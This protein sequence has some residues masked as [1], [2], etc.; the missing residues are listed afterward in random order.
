MWFYSQLSGELVHAC[1]VVGHGYSGTGEGRN[2][3]GMQA[4]ACVGPIPQGVYKIGT[5]YHDPHLG[6]C[7]MH[8][9]PEP[10][11]DTFGRSLFRI[12]G[13]NA[14]NDASEGCVILGPA[15]RASISASLDRD[16]TVIG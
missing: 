14:A 15:V 12:H 13:N 3:P 9:D 10:G 11:T 8:L 2:N 7:V 16:L 5:S 1:R 4:M 6:P